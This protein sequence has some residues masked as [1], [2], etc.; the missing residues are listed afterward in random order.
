MGIDNDAAS[1]SNSEAVEVLTTSNSDQTDAEK[2]SDVNEIYKGSELSMKQF[3][4]RMIL[5]FND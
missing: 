4:K 3:L 1:E 2:T 5:D